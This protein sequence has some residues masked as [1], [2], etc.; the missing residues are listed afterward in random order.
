M[1]KENIQNLLAGPDK[2]WRAVEAHETTQNVFADQETQ[3][4]SQCMAQRK[5]PTS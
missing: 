5:H 1:P 4:V 2:E 3:V